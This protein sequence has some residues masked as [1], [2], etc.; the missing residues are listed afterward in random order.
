ME[1]K[2]D[3]TDIVRERYEK[4]LRKVLKIGPFL[5]YNRDV[6]LGPIGS[7][8]LTG[9]R[10]LKEA[11]RILIDRAAPIYIHQK[12][13]SAVF[14]WDYE[15]SV[16]RAELWKKS[17]LIKEYKADNIDELDS[18]FKNCWKYCKYAKDYEI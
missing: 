18:I 16:F 1:K 10:G 9:I 2:I 8:I 13:G 14:V 15:A 11:K 5:R 7:W 17:N 12:H 6:D 4:R 3:I